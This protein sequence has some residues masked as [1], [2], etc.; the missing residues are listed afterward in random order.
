M[1][2]YCASSPVLQALINSFEV[3]VFFNGDDANLR[4]VAKEEE[5]N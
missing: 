1:N 5:E 4:A 3:E 2:C